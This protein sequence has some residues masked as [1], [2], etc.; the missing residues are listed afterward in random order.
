MIKHKKQGRWP[1][2][3]GWEDRAHDTPD[4]VAV[5]SCQNRDGEGTTCDSW[6]ALCFTELPML[7]KIALEMIA[8]RTQSTS[9]AFRFRNLDSSVPMM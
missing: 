6:I 2:D 8:H 1:H 5:L 7:A 3:Y 9:T 4:H